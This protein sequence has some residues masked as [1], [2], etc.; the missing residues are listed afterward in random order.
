MTIF[1]DEGRPLITADE[2]QTLI[3]AD[4][5]GTI[6]S[7]WETM[8]AVAMQDADAINAEYARDPMALAEALTNV[9]LLR[10]HL[11]QFGEMAD[12]C[13]RRLLAIRPLN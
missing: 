10:S 8:L 11:Q 4:K 12:Q 2:L 7:L 6:G 5:D 13:L 1:L 9:E 3:E